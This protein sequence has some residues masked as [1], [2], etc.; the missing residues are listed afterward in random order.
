[1]R[2]V[3]SAAIVHLCAL[4]CLCVHSSLVVATDWTLSG[5]A[6]AANHVNIVGVEAQLPSGYDGTLSEE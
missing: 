6:G 3:S 1:M 5:I 2:N 4:I